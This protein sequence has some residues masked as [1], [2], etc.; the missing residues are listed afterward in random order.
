MKTLNPW[1]EIEWIS[2]EIFRVNG[3][4]FDLVSWKSPKKVS[5]A[6]RFVLVKDQPFAASMGRILDGMPVRKAIEFGLYHGGNLVLLDAL[7][8]LD[9]AVGIDERTEMPALGEYIEGRGAKDR[10][11]PYLGTDQCE[12]T[13]VTAILER[14]FPERD[15]D[16]IIDDASH[17]YESSKA[18]FELSFEYLRPGGV[19]IIED[20]GWAHWAGDFQTKDYFSG[21]PLS[22]LV[23]ELIMCQAT[24]PLLFDRIHVDFHHVAIFKGERCMEGNNN[25]NINNFY[26]TKRDIILE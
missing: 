25:M 11:F 7:Y 18:T 2:D 16:L 1:C 14:H 20:W 8:G 26:I 15:A 24:T 23:M 19:Y 9:T 5:S 21:V 17:L 4:E 13:A 12:S 22:K 6:T 10:I 3:M